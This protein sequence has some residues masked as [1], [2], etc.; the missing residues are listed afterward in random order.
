M[1]S[2]SYRPAV[3][4]HRHGPRHAKAKGFIPESPSRLPEMDS[5][6]SFNDKNDD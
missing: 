3:P 6:L 5:A 4:K 1:K 2:M